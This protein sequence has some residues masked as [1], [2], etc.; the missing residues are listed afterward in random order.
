MEIDLVSLENDDKM[1]RVIGFVVLTCS[2]LDPR[3]WNVNVEK[4]YPGK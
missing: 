4:F 3:R 2:R 1:S